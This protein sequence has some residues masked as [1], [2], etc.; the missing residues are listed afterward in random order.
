M[1]PEVIRGKGYG[2]EADVWALGIILYE[3]M[4]GYLPFADEIN[5]EKSD[6]VIQTVLDGDLKFPEV[7]DRKAKDLM[8]KIL[9]PHPA[10]RLGC[11][12]G[13]Q[14]IKTH[15]F[16]GLDGMVGFAAAAADSENNG[17]DYY[18]ALLLGRELQAPIGPTIKPI[19]ER[20]DLPT[21]CDPFP[22]SPT[23]AKEMWPKSPKAGG[24]EGRSP[25]Q[26]RDFGESPRPEYV[27]ES[28]P[29]AWKPQI[30]PESNE[31]KADSPQNKPAIPASRTSAQGT[32]PE[33]EA[34]GDPEGDAARRRHSAP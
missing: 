3:L 21:T 13:Y 33:P 19:P 5:P 6:E 22:P 15:P 24:P 18:F 4:V 8:E 28:H 34:E 12:N 9:V 26:S 16:F 7:L 10:N 20:P 1:A 30:T 29:T 14:E 32:A 2:I 23:K 25:E 17:N 31:L 27:S 11:V